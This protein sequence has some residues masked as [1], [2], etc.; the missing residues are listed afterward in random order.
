MYPQLSFSV[1][2]RSISAAIS[3]VPDR[4]RTYML[5]F[6]IADDVA[7][8]VVIALVYSGH[9]NLVALGAG[10]ALLAW[11]SRHAG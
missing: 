10:L 3:S 2:S 7:G 8:I 5:T 9:I 4:V 1:A 11:W 6:A